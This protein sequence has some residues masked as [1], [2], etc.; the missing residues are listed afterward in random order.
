MTNLRNT[1]PGWPDKLPDAVPATED[2]LV[3]LDHQAKTAQMELT[4]LSESLDHLDHRLL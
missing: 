1:S 4:V 3:Q 2:H